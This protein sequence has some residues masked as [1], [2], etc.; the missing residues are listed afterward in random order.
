[1]EERDIQ[2]GTCSYRA[3]PR[4]HQAASNWPMQQSIATQIIIR[5]NK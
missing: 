1:M 3:R 4:N 2:F 5:I